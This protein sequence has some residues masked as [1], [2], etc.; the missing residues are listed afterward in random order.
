LSDG[1]IVFDR[2]AEYYDRTRTLPAYLQDQITDILVDE[3]S[4]RGVCLEPGVGTG[5]IALP[6]HAQG[7]PLVGADLS[8]PMMERLAANAGGAAPFPLLRADVTRLPFPDG[9]FGAVFLCHVLHLVPAWRLAAAEL[10]RIVRPGGA[11]LVDIGD[12]PSEVG[13]AINGEFA[14][15]AGLERPR[16]G[17]TDPADLDAA[18]A[19]LHMPL[20][21]TRAVKFTH[22]Y[23]LAGYLARL[24][25]NQF[26]STWRL[27][28][29]TRAR[30]AAATREW[31][32]QRFGDLDEPRAEEAEITWRVYE[33]G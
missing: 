31:A 20:A 23:N 32:E 24:E 15:R 21:R 3:L 26:S 33:V 4:G 9:R 6:L 12:N 7:I 30:A 28:D 27:D 1:S 16:P 18:M 25:S 13:R 2:A 17:V 19:G 29:E 22:N 14:R 10:V 5:R 8:L 11:V